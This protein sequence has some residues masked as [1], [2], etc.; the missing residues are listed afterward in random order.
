MRFRLTDE[1]DW[2]HE[3]AANDPGALVVGVRR[4]WDAYV[5][6]Q[7]GPVVAVHPAFAPHALQ[8]R[9]AEIDAWLAERLARPGATTQQKRSW[10]AN[11]EHER[12]LARSRLGASFD[13]CRSPLHLHVLGEAT[14]S[15]LSPGN[16]IP[17]PT[18]PWALDEALARELFALSERIVEHDRNLASL[19]IYVA[20]E[21][22]P[23]EPERRLRLVKKELLE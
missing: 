14:G 7:H 20:A 23:P 16:M 5:Q 22:V 11:A 4:A 10:M 3:F 1:R 19:G 6:E 13:P 2:I 21:L 17:S 15:W 18:V 8:Q 12:Y 9:L